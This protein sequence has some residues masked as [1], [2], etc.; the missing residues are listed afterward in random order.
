[1]IVYSLYH[2]QKVDANL[3]QYLPRLLE[4]GIVK[5][6]THGVYRLSGVTIASTDGTRMNQEMK[7]EDENETSLNEGWNAAL[8][9]ADLKKVLPLLEIIKKQGDVSPNELREATGKSKTTI[10]RYLNLLCEHG[11]IESTG[12][13]SAL[14]YHLKPQE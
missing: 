6:D 3:T 12:H 4:L 1:M 14:T 10:W 2:G 8:S 13:T 5:Q 11:L 9:K 7:Q